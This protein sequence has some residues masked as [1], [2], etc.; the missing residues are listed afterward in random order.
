MLKL[1]FHLRRSSPLHAFDDFRVVKAR[2]NPVSLGPNL[3][4]FLDTVIRTLLF[5]HTMSLSVAH[6]E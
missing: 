1:M 4:I 2:L 6:A 3:A 5:M